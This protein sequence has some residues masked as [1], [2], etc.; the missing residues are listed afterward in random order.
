MITPN[1]Y[2]FSRFWVKN[3]YKEICWG[4]LVWLGWREYVEIIW[5]EVWWK[6]L[7]KILVK[8]EG[9]EIVAGAA[10]YYF[11]TSKAPLPATSIPYHQQCLGSHTAS[12]NKKYPF[13]CS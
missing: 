11:I 13:L 9:G 10:G 5:C 12:N 1:K 4:D 3:L 8:T 6:D 7:V 2:K